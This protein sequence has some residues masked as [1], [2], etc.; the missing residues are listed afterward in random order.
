[1]CTVTC[2]GVEMFFT[3]NWTF[4]QKDSTTTDGDELS[5]SNIAHVMKV[6]KEILDVVFNMFA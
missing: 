5:V 2:G 6:N 3:C 4:A 1:M